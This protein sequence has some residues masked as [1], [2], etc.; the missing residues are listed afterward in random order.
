MAVTVSMSLACREIWKVQGWVGSG[1]SIASTMT[2]AA[3]TPGFEDAGAV[4]SPR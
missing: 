3:V 1:E 2:G 4:Q